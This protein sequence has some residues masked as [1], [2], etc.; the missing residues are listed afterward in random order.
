MLGKYHSSSAPKIENE[1]HSHLQSE[2]ETTEQILRHEKSAAGILCQLKTRHFTQA[3][4]LTLT[5]DVLG[6]VATLGKVDEEN[7]SRSV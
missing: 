4:H 5:K 7:L 2:D 1:D 3:S 6:A